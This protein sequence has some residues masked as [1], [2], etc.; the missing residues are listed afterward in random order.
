[1]YSI[2]AYFLSSAT[3]ILSSGLTLLFQP[4][5][6]LF[7]YIPFALKG[8]PQLINKDKQHSWLTKANLSWLT[9][10]TFNP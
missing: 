10:A 4:P 7:F 3:K 8:S 2:T 6:H 5:M 1:M 9:K